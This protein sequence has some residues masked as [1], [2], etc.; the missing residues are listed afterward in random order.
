MGK[1]AYPE[2]HKALLDQALYPQATRRIKF[3]ETRSSY[4]YRT[5][6]EVYKVRKPASQYTSLAVKEALLRDVLARGRTWAPEVFVDLVPIVAAGGAFSLGGTGDPVDL[7]LRLKQLPERGWV[8]GL[9]RQQKLMPVS[10]GRLARYLAEHHAQLRAGEKD[11]D[12][13]RPEHFQEL[14][15]EVCTQTRR[16]IDL[17]LSKAMYDQ[18]TLPIGRF[19]EGNRKLFLRRQKKARVVEGHG[20]FVPEH[21]YLH[22]REV[23]AVSPLEGHK[24]FRVL[25][26]ASDVATFVNGL[27]LLDAREPAEL[28]ARRY[29]DVTK[30]R[31][32]P[33]ILPAYQVLQALRCGCALSEW[34]AE[35]SLEQEHKDEV[36]A[37]AH[38]VLGLAVELARALLPL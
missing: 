11:Q 12:A 10:V 23:Y 15:E 31:D 13:A 21:V 33:Q 25:D 32:L 7:A 38:R 20:A 16:C 6:T 36:T 28:F 4:L 34:L 19:V 3:Q 35:G 30:D 8:D 5:G 26:A 14:A 1:K 9:V 27:L 29:A 37:K 18:A 24:R 17:T 22:G 2:F